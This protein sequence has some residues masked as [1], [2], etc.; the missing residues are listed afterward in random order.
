MTEMND[1]K[2]AF[3][4]E[5]VS[6]CRKYKLTLGACGCCQSMWIDNLEDSLKLTYGAES[7]ENIKFYDVSSLDGHE[8]N[9]IEVLAENEG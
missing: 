1:E 6:L 2:L 3:L 4:K 7:Y 8:I 9:E 5:Y